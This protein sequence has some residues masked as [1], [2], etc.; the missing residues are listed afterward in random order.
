MADEVQRIDEPSEGTVWA[1]CRAACPVHIDVPGYLSAVAEGRFTDALEIVLER[2][3]LPSVCGRVCL[4]PCEEGCRRCQVDS[5]VAIAALKRAAADHGLYPAHQPVR[6]RPEKIAIVGSGPTGLTAAY[7]LAAEG[8]QVTIYEAKPLLGGMMRYGIPEYR[9][10][11]RALD[12]DIEHVLNRG[13]NARTGVRI[14]ED[15]TLD[16][17]R[18]EHDAVLLAVGLQDSRGLPIEGASAPR[19]MYALPFLEASSRK[20]PVDVGDRVV[21]VGGGNVAMDV[22]RTALR[23]GARKVTCVCL[24]SRNEMPASDHE[25]REAEN[26]GVSI[27]CSWGPL[28]V[29]CDGECVT[30]LEAQLCE[31]V[32]DRD[33][34]F[35][36]RFDESIRERFPADTVIFAIG[37][38][39]DCTD[40]GVP[41]TSRGGIETHPLTLQTPVDGV[42]AAGDVI[43]GPTKI[44]DAVSAGHQ[45]A[46]AIIADLTGDMS[47]LADLAAENATLGQVPKVV[48]AKLETRRRVEMEELEYFERNGF[49]EI[50]L[51]Y[52][53]YEAAREAQRCLSCTT[54]ARLTQEKCASCLTCARVCPHGAPSIQLGGYPYFSADACH[55]CGACASEC[56]AHAIVLEGCSER[57]MSLKVQRELARPQ[58]NQMLAFV[59][60]YTPEFLASLEEDARIITVPCLLRVSERAVLE[61]LEIGANRVVFS[62]CVEDMCRFPHA[63]PLVAN[64]VERIKGLL[65]QA[66]L[67][68]HFAAETLDQQGDEGTDQ[69]T[70][71]ASAPAHAE[72]REAQG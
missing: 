37:Q 42:Y 38:G 8:Y 18:A 20:E 69:D 54:G 1:P 40:L 65:R 16:E 15:I 19:V 11:D 39:A 71:D 28:A 29:Q 4:R 45:A 46:S 70:D 56:P 41:I 67:E 27:R 61:S 57:E 5:P 7:D 68:E 2:N 22:A 13:V 34:N 10:P 36:P 50:E 47:R 49:E 53:E 23:Q 17:L 58:Y 31:A 72:P 30:G 44:I 32:F 60:G 62:P 52:T 66:G 6:Q 24:E 64:R 9:L 14:G 33:G 48:A 43:S 25:V 63:M 12:R 26:E 35:S 55:A 51:G 59:C 3:P 21:V